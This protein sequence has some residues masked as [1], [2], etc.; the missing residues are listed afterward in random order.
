MKTCN[1]CHQEKAPEYFS[2]DKYTKDLLDGKCKKCK[3]EKYS[4]IDKK[5]RAEWRKSYYEMHRERELNLCAS[6]R[7]SNRA[8]INSYLSEYYKT[9]PGKSAAKTAKYRANRLKATPPWLTDSQFK[10]I[11]KIY[12]TCPKGHDVDHIIPLQGKNVK[13]LHVPWNLQHLPSSDNKRKSN[14]LIG[15]ECLTPINNSDENVR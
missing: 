4:Q 13:G 2:K 7:S 8:K 12:E 10:E 14:R 11:I 15:Q 9:R 5:T 1:I 3:S 6:Y